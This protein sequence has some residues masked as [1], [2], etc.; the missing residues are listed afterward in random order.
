M[1]EWMNERM[2]EWMNEWMNECDAWTNESNNQPIQTC[3][4]RSFL[5]LHLLFERGV[6]RTGQEASVRVD[7]NQIHHHLEGFIEQ[8][9]RYVVK[10]NHERLRKEMRTVAWDVMCVVRC[11]EHYEGRDAVV[12]CNRRCVAWYPF[13]NSY[14]H[15]FDTRCPMCSTPCDWVGMQAHQ[16][17]SKWMNED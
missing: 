2:N 10:T 1:N 7:L 12:H 13:S 4:S 3:D 11:N 6:V 15:W 17:D 16:I 9:G 8:H 5:Q 14:P